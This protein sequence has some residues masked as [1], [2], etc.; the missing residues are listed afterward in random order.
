MTP[1]AWIIPVLLSLAMV[2]ASEDA[3]QED[4]SEVE[5]LLL[6]DR[7]SYMQLVARGTVVVDELARVLADRDSEDTSRMMAANALGDIGSTKA[8]EPLLGA[9][10]DPWFNIRRCAALALGKIRD[11]RAK[12]PLEKLASEDPFVW[13]DPETGAERYLVREDALLALDL[14]AGKVA[15]DVAG[16]VKE[17]EVFLD[18]ASKLPPSPAKIEIRRLSFPFPGGFEEQNVFNNY[19]QPTDSYV[20]AALDILHPPG[21]EVRAV[22]GGRAALVATN[23]PEWKTHHFFIV[24]PEGEADEGWCYTHVDPDTLTFEIGE[25]VQ[26]GQVLGKLVDFYVGKNKGA[27][28]LHLHYVRFSRKPDGNVDVTSLI[29]PL[30][31]FDWEDER[32]PE[33][34]APIRFVK[35]GTTEE[36][37]AGKDGLPTVSGNVDV[38]AGISDAAY[39]DQG[40]N[41][42]VPVVT[43]EIVGETGAPWRKLVLDQRGEIAEPRAAPA[44]YVRR[45]DAQHWKKDLPSF[46]T[47]HF[48]FATHTDGDGALESGDA[49]QNWSTTETVSDGKPRFPNGEYQVTIRAWDLKEQRAERTQ[50]VRVEN[51]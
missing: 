43:I 50:K 27:D 49:L 18:D 19:Q 31:F 28:H 3:T 46:P 24:T 42:M 11:E 13:K 44:L 10:E 1:R 38:I 16:L 34:H 7:R 21:T 14:L 35:A 51:P 41:W 22:E 37:P 15:A 40:C 36:F 39:A 2:S 47:P 33:V 5:R 29:D 4:V 8:V 20:H 9:L 45:D 48:L 6:G 30:L 26:Q 32:A 25:E 23:Y 12:A 17:K